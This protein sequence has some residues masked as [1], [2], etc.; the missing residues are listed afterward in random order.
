MFIASE[1]SLFVATGTDETHLGPLPDDSLLTGMEMQD[2]YGDWHNGSV[3]S[4][5]DVFIDLPS[6]G[7]NGERYMWVL[8][9][10]TTTQGNFYLANVT[11]TADQFSAIPEPSTLLL[12]GGGLA[13]LVRLRKKFK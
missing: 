9:G 7:P 6:T 8:S 4:F 11:I 10:L 3:D 13:G 1:K 2:G 12:F 5:F